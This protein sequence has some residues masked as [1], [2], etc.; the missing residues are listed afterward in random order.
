MGFL[1]LFPGKPYQNF[2]KDHSWNKPNTLCYSIYSEYYLF[3]VNEMLKSNLRAEANDFVDFLVRVPTKIWPN[4]HLKWSK[5][6]QLCFKMTLIYI[7]I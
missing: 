2:L 4:L 5:F 1:R 7:F 6:I 3:F